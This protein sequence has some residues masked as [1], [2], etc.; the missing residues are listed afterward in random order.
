MTKSASL[1]TR[2]V[3]VEITC[4]V[5]NLI[6]RCRLIPIWHFA[7]LKSMSHCFHFG[8]NDSIISV[9]VY[10]KLVTLCYFPSSGSLTHQSR[11]IMASDE[12][13]VAIALATVG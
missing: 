1:D 11:I 7:R 5:L 10:G 6:S 4:S 13:F 8:Q 9:I 2:V 3:S 12:C